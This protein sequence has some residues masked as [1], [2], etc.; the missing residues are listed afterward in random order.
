[1]NMGT[2]TI[3]FIPYSLNLN[4]KT[5]AYSHLVCKL[6][7]YKTDVGGNLIDY[8]GNKGTP[9]SYQEYINSVISTTDTKLCTSDIKTSTS[10]LSARI[11]IPLSTHLNQRDFYKIMIDWTGRQY[12][13]L[14]MNRN[15]L[16]QE[17]CQYIHVRI[18]KKSA[19]P[20]PT[21]TT[22]TPP[23]FATRMDASLI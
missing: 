6:R 18:C 1:M 23:I 14:T 3:G 16:G 11:R 5:V 13:R 19:H 21:Y 22:Y 2:G 10:A 17:L 4:N 8:A 9:S 12:C 20:L 15:L 7:L